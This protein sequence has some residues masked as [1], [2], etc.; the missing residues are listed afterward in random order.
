ML[1]RKAVRISA[2][3]EE[4]NR[5]HLVEF[6][7][8]KKLAEQVGSDSRFDYDQK[9]MAWMESEKD[10]AAYAWVESW[11]DFDPYAPDFDFPEPMEEVEED[12]VDEFEQLAQA[13]DV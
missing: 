7:A 13:A 3:L 5:A 12:A 11:E 1:E 2:P 6:E 8:M 9:S 4:A 10:E